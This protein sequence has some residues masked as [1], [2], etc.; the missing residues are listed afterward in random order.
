MDEIET[1]RGMT[2]RLYDE[3]IGKVIAKTSL[4]DREQTAYFGL[5]FRVRLEMGAYD[6]IW[7]TPQSFLDALVR[8]GLMDHA[9][10][11]KHAVRLGADRLD[12][13]D[14]AREVCED[15]LS[16]MAKA[17]LDGDDTIFD[18]AVFDFWKRSE[19]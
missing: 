17:H 6:G 7:Q 13:D 19:G 11:L 16:E 4:T 2:Y 15:E 18:R 8:L 14:N 3:L 12:W 5:G 9:R 10:K 1:I